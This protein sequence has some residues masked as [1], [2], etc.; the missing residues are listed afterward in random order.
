M[1]SSEF[2]LRRLTVDSFR[3]FRDSAEFDLDATTVIF[4]GPNGTGKTSVFDAL[5]WVLLGTIKR[6]EGLRVRQNVEHIVNTYRP[7]DRATAALNILVNGKEVTIRR[8]GHYEHS[9]LEIWEAAGTSLFG[10]QAEKWLGEKLV[11]QDPKALSTVLMTCGLLQQ[12]V[13]MSVLEAKAA[14]RYA[15]ISVILG[16]GELQDFERAIQSA[17][18][19]ANI[20][21]DFARGKVR[22]SSDAVRAATSQLEV[23]KRR[24]SQ[25]ASVEVVQGML[26]TEVKQAPAGITI[27]IPDALSAEIARNIAEHLRV[28]QQR[29][30]SLLERADNLRRRKKRLLPAITSYEPRQ[31]NQSAREGSLSVKAAESEE[32][33]AMTDLS[34]AQDASQH[35]EQLAAIAVPL[36][37]EKCPVC[38]QSIDPGAVKEHLQKL[39]SSATSLL[40]FQQRADAAA[41]KVQEARARQ[42]ELDKEYAAVV[43]AVS[44]W[45]RFNHDEFAL[46]TGVSELVR[47]VHESISL[48]DLDEDEFDHWGPEAGQF[49]GRLA[50]VLE[51]YSDTVTNS[52]T[53]GEIERAESELQNAKALLEDARSALQQGVARTTQ[54]RQLSDAVKAARVDVT[55]SRF[56][57]IEPLVTDIYS[58]LDPHPTF[59]TL[60]FKH[61]I[62][63][64]KG[65]SNPVVTDLTAKVEGDP[66]IIF[67]A[68]QANIAALSY[69]LA[70]NLGA[71]ERALPFVLLDDP[72]QSMDDVNALG[73]ADLCRF[74]RA[75]RQLMLSTHDRR[76]GDL[77]RRKLAPRVSQDRTVV[78]Q[79]V[80]WD[81]RGP[82]VDTESLRYEADNAR[83]RLLGR[84]ALEFTLPTGTSR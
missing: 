22:E 58:R 13:M 14:D 82:S 25:Q 75:E 81:R 20:R 63:Y 8:K 31:L 61:G 45:D 6:L 17:A 26:R 55:T 52:E 57:A 40:E 54:L 65:T 39:D 12:D 10:D 34:R 72:M 56:A 47:N 76:F 21:N 59:K 74:L 23:L 19:E 64:G 36:L 29:I 67:S 15:H 16:L 50:L 5:Q 46:N 28:L 9:T 84:P 35:W 70:M 69:F 3:G 1:T 4:A 30:A 43:E 7:G 27:D 53:S 38:G 79:F 37:T 51:T 24:R 66:R 71:G 18:K 44:Q 68:S 33:Q 41:K 83:L 77:L 48:T 2:R 60:G 32:K 73:F 78:H 49:L 42:Q 11:P 62:Y 80:G